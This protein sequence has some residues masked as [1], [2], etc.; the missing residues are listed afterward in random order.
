MW[1]Q[2][3]STAFHFRLRGKGS[4]LRPEDKA[5]AAVPT[6]TFEAAKGVLFCY[7]SCMPRNLTAIVLALTLTLPAFAKDKRPAPASA[8]RADKW[9]EKTLRKL[10]VEEKIGQ[11]FMIWCRASFLNVEAPEYLQWRDAMQKYHIGSFAMTVHVDGPFLLRSEPYEEAELINRLQRESKLPLIFAAD[12]ER[13]V[14]TRLMGT[15]N[16][17]H[18]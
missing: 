9:A 14:A 7:R 6:Q 16:F 1:G 15:T 17:P 4:G 10:T 18:A 12:F 11:V 8:S 3:P 2:P 5:R 13:G